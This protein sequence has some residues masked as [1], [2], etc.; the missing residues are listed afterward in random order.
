MGRR[1]PQLHH[2]PRFP[3]WQGGPGPSLRPR[4]VLHQYLQALHSV[5]V[6]RSGLP[7][8]HRGPHL[9]CCLATHRPVEVGHPGEI[10]RKVLHSKKNHWDGLD[11]GGWCE[12]EEVEVPRRRPPRQVAGVEQPVDQLRALP[13]KEVRLAALQQGQQV[14][15]VRV[16]GSQ[17]VGVHSKGEEKELTIGGRHGGRSGG[18]R[19]S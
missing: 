11:N 14:Q 18:S 8:G 13:Q 2:H 17:A 16:A 7:D 10:P 1:L 15:G 19:D 5:R 6:A 4:R 9:Y 12:I 3:L